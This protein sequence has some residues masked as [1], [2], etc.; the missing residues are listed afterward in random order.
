MGELWLDI[1]I[2]LNVVL[3]VLRVVLVGVGFLY[4]IAH[5]GSE[6]D[7]VSH[8][9]WKTILSDCTKEP[10]STTMS[11]TSHTGLRIKVSLILREFPSH[12]K[13]FCPTLK[14][15]I[16]N[17]QRGAR[18]AQIR[19]QIRPQEATTTKNATR[20]TEKH[21]GCC[22][23][24]RPRSCQS[25]F[26]LILPVFFLQIPQELINQCKPTGYFSL[27]FSLTPS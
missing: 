12:C 19:Q 21:M 8:Q 2:K 16:M 6:Q 11:E 5:G 9:G 18:S 10:I 15:V 4:E 7:A 26:P 23:R 22:S 13:Q 27:K 20:R 14:Y 17:S 24:R 25:Q 3:V 1:L